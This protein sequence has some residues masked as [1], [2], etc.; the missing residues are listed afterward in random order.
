LIK[1]IPNTPQ[2]FLRCVSILLSDVLQSILFIWC[3]INFFH[4]EVIGLL[5]A[6]QERAQGLIEYGLAII[7][8]AIVII[9]ILFWIGPSVGNMFSNI[10]KQ[11]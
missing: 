7:L 6:P 8:I 5:F 2:D 11:L 9:L 1:R 4:K 3:L 10:V